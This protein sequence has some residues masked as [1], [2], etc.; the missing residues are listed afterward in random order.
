MLK[1]SFV[2]GSTVLRIPRKKRTSNTGYVGI[3]YIASSNTHQ[4]C[5]G[6]RLLGWRIK[7]DDAIALRAEGQRR[8]KDGTFNDWYTALMAGRSKR[9]RKRK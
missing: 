4:V 3:H 1:R 2:D 9:G 6:S 5:I 7:L 8:I